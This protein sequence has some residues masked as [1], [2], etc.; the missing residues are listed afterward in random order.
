MR[1][2]EEEGQLFIY[3]NNCEGGCRSVPVIVV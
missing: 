3:K 1:R 2:R